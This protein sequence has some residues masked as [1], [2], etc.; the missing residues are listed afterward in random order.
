MLINEDRQLLST[1]CRTLAFYNEQK[2]MQDRVASLIGARAVQLTAGVP[3]IVQPDPV[4]E[5]FMTGIEELA[6]T[7]ISALQALAPDLAIEAQS[8]YRKYY[9]GFGKLVTCSQDGITGHNRVE[10]WHPDLLEPLDPVAALQDLDAALNADMQSM[11]HPEDDS[12]DPIDLIDTPQHDLVLGMAKAMFALIL[13]SYESC[14]TFRDPS[15]RKIDAERFRLS[16]RS[17]ELHEPPAFGE[18]LLQGNLAVLGQM[19]AVY[20]SDI[21]LA[22]MDQMFEQ[23]CMLAATALVSRRF[24]LW[25]LVFARVPD[26]WATQL[27]EQGLSNKTTLGMLFGLCQFAEGVFHSCTIG[28]RLCRIR[29]TKDANQSV[30]NWLEHWVGTGARCA[31]PACDVP[32]AV[33]DVQDGKNLFRGVPLGQRLAVGVLVRRSPLKLLEVNEGFARKDCMPC[34]VTPLYRSYHPTALPTQIGFACLMHHSCRAQRGKLR[35]GGGRSEATA[36]K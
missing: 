12:R 16:G 24:W 5:Q 18:A 11:F 1:T 36:Q 10:N 29:T 30:K 15:T 33:P 22:A 31:I 8:I 3:L 9:G 25:N 32:L 17:D 4:A 14:E 19:R 28:A 21:P 34:L 20:E 27:Q 2:E 13:V 6:D 23:L 26:L 7:M 35:R